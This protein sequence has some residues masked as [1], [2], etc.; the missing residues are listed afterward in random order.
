MPD[1]SL[2]FGLSYAALWIVVI[3]QGVILLGVVRMVYQL[4]RVG[5]SRLGNQRGDEAPE[6]SAVDL[7][8]TMIRSVE[9]AGHL[10]ALLFVSPS[11]RACST[12][13]AE[14]DA[15]SYKTDGNMMVI[16][17]AE[18]GDC[19]QLAAKYQ[20]SVPTIVDD[21][22]RIS[23]LFSVATVPTAVLINEENHI[24]SY[25]HP[26]R[27]EEFEEMLDETRDTETSV[28]G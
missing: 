7:T 19:I 10:T 13:L 3:L 8:G 16:C 14:M 15:L 18:R 24:H 22:R 11:C 27:G 23:N 5:V 28:A 20:L 9:F 21:D 4:Q 17:Q 2:P 12:T 25:G 1:L 26:M 6:F